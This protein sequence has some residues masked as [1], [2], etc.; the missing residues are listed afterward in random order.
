MCSAWTKT[1]KKRKK[2]RKLQLNLQIYI[3]IYIL[4]ERYSVEGIARDNGTNGMRH[5]DTETLWPNGLYLSINC[6]TLTRTP[7]VGCVLFYP[8][9]AASQLCSCQIVL[10]VFFFHLLLCV[11]PNECGSIATRGGTTIKWFSPRSAT[12]V[13]ISQANIDERLKAIENGTG[14]CREGSSLE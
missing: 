1:K 9:G 11:R 6:L 5:W 14:K 10:C 8:V 13:A 12:T 2:N 7:S 3:Y 4:Y